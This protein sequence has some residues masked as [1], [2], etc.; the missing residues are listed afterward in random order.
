MEDPVECLAT[1][2][3]FSLVYTSMRILEF[4]YASKKYFDTFVL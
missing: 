2:G 1:L 3:R 4:F